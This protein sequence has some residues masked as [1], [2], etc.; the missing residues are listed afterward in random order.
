MKKITAEP[1][2]TVLTITLGFLVTYIFTKWNWALWSSLGVGAI[3]ILSPYLAKKIVFIWMKLTT[4]L[5]FIVPNVLL[6][7]IFFVFLFPIAIFSKFFSKKKDVLQLRNT[8]ESLFKVSH[9]KFPKASFEKP[10]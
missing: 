2:K 8:S 10:W 6:T 5:S 3:G 1:I 9:K 7:L 4:V